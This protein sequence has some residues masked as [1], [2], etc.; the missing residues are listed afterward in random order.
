M[1]LVVVSD[2]SPD[3][4]ACVGEAAA[5][6]ER[7]IVMRVLP[8]SLVARSSSPA[9]AGRLR[10]QAEDGARGEVTAQLD[11]VAPGVDARIVVVFGDVV[12]DTVLVAR[13]LDAEAIAIDADDPSRHDLIERS[14][15]PV[16][17][18]GSGRAASGDP[19]S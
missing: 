19:G 18:F 13:N 7:L 9:E 15:V 8:G 1:Q 3:T 5:R 17:V 14:P 6:A 4:D 12:F 11:R 2:G 16:L 10:R